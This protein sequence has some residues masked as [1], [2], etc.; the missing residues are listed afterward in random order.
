[1]IFFASVQRYANTLIRLKMKS[2][3]S[4]LVT[5]ELSVGKILN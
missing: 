3:G 2:L 1:M 4:T 5:R